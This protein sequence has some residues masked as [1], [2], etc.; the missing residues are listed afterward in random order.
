MKV[1]QALFLFFLLPLA[2]AK[3]EKSVI[4]FLIAEREYQTNETL[5][6]FAKENL[7]GKYII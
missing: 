2:N 3:V 6:V 1:Y 7:G 4:V 5:P